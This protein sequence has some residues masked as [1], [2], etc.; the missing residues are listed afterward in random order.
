[1]ITVLSCPNLS[2]APPAAFHARHTFSSSEDVSNIGANR[3]GIHPDPPGDLEQHTKNQDKLPN[4]KTMYS[5]TSMTGHYI[6][7]CLLGSSE[8]SHIS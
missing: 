7:S 8:A 1:M 2:R 4:P 5:P 6:I 3:T